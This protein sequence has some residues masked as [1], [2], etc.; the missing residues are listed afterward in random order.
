MNIW[1]FSERLQWFV[2]SPQFFLLFHTNASVLLIWS[3]FFVNFFACI[4]LLCT[5]LKLQL[6]RLSHAF[7]FLTI[8]SPLL[9][10]WLFFVCWVFLR[11]FLSPLRFLILFLCFFKKI[12]EFLSGIFVLC[13]FPFFF[14]CVSHPTLCLPFIC[15]FLLEHYPTLLC[16]HPF[17]QPRALFPLIL[18]IE[19][20]GS[21]VS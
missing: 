14:L 19:H 18:I 2:H 8:F 4:F 16:A 1:R 6:F 10:F 5:K 15:P 12:F 13:T 17:A 11:R 7:I 3:L 21:P 9:L 20:F